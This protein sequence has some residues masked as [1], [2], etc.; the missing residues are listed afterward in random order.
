MSEQKINWFPEYQD[1][2]SRLSES[3]LK[4]V[5]ALLQD[6]AYTLLNT[7]ETGGCVEETC[8]ALIT[9]NKTSIF[10]LIRDRRRLLH[11]IEDVSY[12]VS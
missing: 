10:Q 12:P 11:Y 5:E 2:L 7:H 9:E 8:H 4:V 1:Q 6:I 3:E